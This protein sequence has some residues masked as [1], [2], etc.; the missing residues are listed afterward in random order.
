[1]TKNFLRGL[2]GVGLTIFRRKLGKGIPDLKVVEKLSLDVEFGNFSL[3]LSSHSPDLTQTNIP[4]CTVT[5]IATVTAISFY[6]NI[7][8]ILLLVNV[9]IFPRLTV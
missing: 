7:V 5:N 8:S 4:T 2:G 9:S 3:L 1:M 6:T